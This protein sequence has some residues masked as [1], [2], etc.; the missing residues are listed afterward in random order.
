MVFMGTVI[1]E[2]GEFNGAKFVRKQPDIL[3]IGLSEL[4]RTDKKR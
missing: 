1:N 4:V 2:P 3:G